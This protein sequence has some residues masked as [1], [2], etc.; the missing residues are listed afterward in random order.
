MY[1]MIS[2]LIFNYSDSLYSQYKYTKQS[3]LEIS[4]SGSYLFGGILPVRNGDLNFVNNYGFQGDL[5]YKLTYGTSAGI[6][7]SFLPTELRFRNFQ[8]YGIESK[9]FDMDIH[10]FYLNYLVQKENRNAVLFGLVGF[11][12]VVFDPKD[13]YYRSEF[14]FAST[15]GGG[16][17]IYPSGRVGIKIQARLLLP[18]YSASAGIFAGPG[19]VGYGV[20]GTSALIQADLSAGFTFKF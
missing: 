3:K 7:Y 13:N 14:R 6:S 2:V 5:T 20:G 12:G 1:L 9:L 17:K 10:Y 11:G 15:L 8:N 4:A 18:I 16:I 19:G